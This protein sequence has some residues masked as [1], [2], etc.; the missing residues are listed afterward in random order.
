[1]R[2][3]ILFPL[4]APLS[5]L[6]GIGPKTA[7]LFENLVGGGLVRDVVFHAPSRVIDR[8]VRVGAAHAPDG[9]IATLE[10]QIEEHLPSKNPR[11]PYRVRTRDETG[12]LTLTWFHAKGDYLKRLAPEGAVR[13][14]SGKVERFGSEIQMLHP[15]YVVDPGKPQDAPPLYE[16][17]YPLTAGLH[18]KPVRKALAGAVATL[19][20]LADWMDEALL[21]RQGWPGWRE[22]VATLHAPETSDDLSPNAP[23]RARLAYDEML[24]EQ[25]TLALIRERRRDVAGRVLDGPNTSVKRLLEASPFE[26]T[27]AQKRAARD[28]FD[29]MAAPHR[30]GRLLQ[31]DVG[32]G[33]TFVAALAAAKAAASSVQIAIM[34]PTEI[35]ARQH[36]SNLEPLL[37]AADISCA[38]LTG[39]DK[40]KARQSILQ[41]IADGDVDVVCGT[42]ALFQDDVVF[43]DLG[44][45]II[46]EQHRFGVSDRLKLSAKGANADLLVMTAT[47]IP[48]TLTLAS[49][50]DLDVSRLDEKPPGRTPIDTRVMAMDRLED[51]MDAVGRAIEKDDRVYWVC[52]LVEESEV[53]DLS[54]ADERWRELATLFGE[55][56]VGLLHG[57]MSA[58][59]K[60]ARA[61]AFRRGEIDI[62]VATTVIEVGVDAPDA[63]IMVIEHAERFGLAQLHQLRG[64]VGRGSKAS[65]CVLVYRPPLSDTAKQRLDVMRRTEDGFVIA[66]EDWR[67]RGPGQMLGAKQSGMP[68]YRL[69][70][71]EHHGDLLEIAAKDAA[72][73]VAR[74]PQLTSERGQA[75]RVLLHLFDAARAIGLLAAG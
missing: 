10:V 4:F 27:G 9:E 49:F 12:Y 54:A 16:P 55:G 22:A 11:R 24:A 3:E 29:D 8:S 19:P 74:D 57:K 17:V 53:S 63:T 39:R 44:L 6:P 64:R 58:A 26:P 65:T 23:A 73:I 66:E 41:R 25:L 2:P 37:G 35:L 38:A 67:L 72:A 60:E 52:P 43:A 50:G 59:D 13:I 46:D 33:K 15:D 20:D 34:A 70:N 14:V 48:R 51:L 69:A 61:Q 30:M 42:H 47:P 1:M 28:I 56:R 31:G 75:L 18:A 21:A 7:P 36:Y 62:L 45:V 5:S 71:L 40:G 68:D 32:A